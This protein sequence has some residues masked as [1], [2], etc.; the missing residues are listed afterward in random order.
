VAY[1]KR[2]SDALLQ[3]IDWAMEVDPLLRPQSVA[4]FLEALLKETPPLVEEPVSTLGKL[5][6]TWLGKG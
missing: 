3:A 5:A 2:Y 6:S 1:R 4:A